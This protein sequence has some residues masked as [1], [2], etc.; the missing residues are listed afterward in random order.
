MA[1]FLK[2]YIRSTL[3][4]NP[5]EIVAIIYNSAPSEVQRVWYQLSGDE[6]T[7]PET[8]I[9]AVSNYWTIVGV[10]NFRNSFLKKID[11]KK[12]NQ[13]AKVNAMRGWYGMFKEKLFEVQKELAKAKDNGIIE[14]SF[15]QQNADIPGPWNEDAGVGQSYESELSPLNPDAGGNSGKSWDEIIGTI[16]NLVGQGAG[17]A[18]QLSG[19][20]LGF[21]NPQ[22]KANIDNQN[23]L[24][25]AQINAQAKKQ[26]N[27]FMIIGAGMLVV[28]VIV[29][30]IAFRK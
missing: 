2:S 23:A 15:A 21:T 10:D 3:D 30:V 6:I 26:Q 25:Q 12:V 17:V 13:E 16:F 1:N 7:E 18:D 29:I 27:M 4:F 22:Q 5:E 24:V 9:N 8:L 19:T 20:I 28:L 14:K 11:M